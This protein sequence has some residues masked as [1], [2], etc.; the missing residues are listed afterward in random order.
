METRRTGFWIA[1]FG[2]ATIIFWAG[3][4]GSCAAQ[5]ATAKEIVAADNS[6]TNGLIFK[7]RTRRKYTSTINMNRPE[8][9]PE[10]PAEPQDEKESDR[11]N[12]LDGAGN[13]A[14]SILRPSMAPTN[15]GLRPSSR[16]MHTGRGK[17]DEEEDWL[18]TPQQRI[19][20]QIDLLS[21]KDSEEEDEKK[22]GFGWLADEVADIRQ[23]KE[24]EQEE[25][26]RQADEDAEADEIA[27]IL[28]R[29]LFGDAAATDAAQGLLR[30]DRTQMR[31]VTAHPSI[32]SQGT[33]NRFSAPSLRMGKRGGGYS[34]T[35]DSRSADAGNRTDGNSANSTP[36][37]GGGRENELEKLNARVTTGGPAK[38]SS[39]LSTQ[40][41][42]SAIEGTTDKTGANRESMGSSAI[43]SSPFSWDS[44]SGGGFAGLPASVAPSIMPSTGTKM[45]GISDSSSMMPGGAT[46]SGRAAFD[47][48]AL[49]PRAPGGAIR[50]GL[51]DMN[52]PSAGLKPR[53]DARGAFNTPSRTPF[54]N[55][56]V[57]P[58]SSPGSMGTG[59]S[60]WRP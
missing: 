38:S 58:I 60:G 22:S 25:Q 57:S 41:S 37:G 23:K 18:L 32:F 21:G 49:F 40:A 14:E 4:P 19:Q 28:G 29:D 2:A 52:V 45:T 56:M 9:T 46:V 51:G 24:E 53:E 15:P 30:D 20:K 59:I 36:A 33:T 8:E 54:L 6:I 11:E 12:L 48:S 3:V 5:D 39:P 47:S 31:N 26:Q 34:E 13:A 50:S 16:R 7:K 17:K 35:R 55:P 1:V 44:T 42:H 43:V 27:S 10:A